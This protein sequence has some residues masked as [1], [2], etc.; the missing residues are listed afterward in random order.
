MLHERRPPREASWGTVPRAPEGRT[1]LSHWAV[2]TSRTTTAGHVHQR[3]S[4]RPDLAA[5]GWRQG[6]QHLS[7]LGESRTGRPPC[8]APAAVVKAAS[9]CH[10]RGLGDGDSLTSPTK[11]TRLLG[12]GS[13][14]W[15]GAGYAVRLSQYELLVYRR[16]RVVPS[17]SL[18]TGAATS[19]LTSLAPSSEA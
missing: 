10:V 13:S 3:H 19:G 6:T 8:C 2:A 18:A 17:P 1:A 4:S 12:V 11:D 9:V 14:A 7:G 15:L 5:P 16:P